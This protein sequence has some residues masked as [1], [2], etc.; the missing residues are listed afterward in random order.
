MT[1][2]FVR[3]N[4]KEPFVNIKLICASFLSLVVLAHVIIFA[5]FTQRTPSG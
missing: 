2:F 5:Y 4:Q 1:N 3:L